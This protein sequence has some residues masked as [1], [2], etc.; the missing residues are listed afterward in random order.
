MSDVTRILSQI[1]QGDPSAAEQLLPIVYDELKKMAAA[2]LSREK[3][4][5][6]LQPTALVHEAWVRLM[7]KEGQ[8]VNWANRRHFFGAAAESMR[9]I[10]VD[11][12]RRKARPKHGGNQPRVSLE[13][14]DVA[15]QDSP[16]E[17]LLIDEAFDRLASED[18][19]AAD[20]VKLC[21][22][23]GLDVE[24]AAKLLEISRATAYRHWTYAKAWLHAEV[25][26]R[27]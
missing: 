20:V 25:K 13:H 4:G 10:L 24:E 11:V 14:V 8:S 2:K 27:D 16:D 7:G 18:P 6:T 15:G 26:R 17:L 23:A 21:Y 19:I 9:R 22:F 1:E 5:Q 12:A 3:P